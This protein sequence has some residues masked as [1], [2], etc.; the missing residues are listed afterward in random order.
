MAMY[1]NTSKDQLLNISFTELPIEAVEELQSLYKQFYKNDVP[2]DKAKL[3]ATQLLTQFSA[4]YKPLPAKTDKT[5]K[6]DKK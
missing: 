4:L 5:D 2:F 3:K 1:P 6:T